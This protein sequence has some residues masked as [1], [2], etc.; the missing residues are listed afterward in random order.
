[1]NEP[2]PPRDPTELP[3][4]GTEELALGYVPPDPDELPPVELWRAVGDVRPW[5]TLLVLFPCAAM[6]LLL[7]A[8]HA[9]G[10]DDALL[11]WGANATRLPPLESAW[12]LIAS[13]FLHAGPGHLF[14]NATTLIIFG[15][16]VERVFTRWG[17]WI[18]Y[19]AGGA[20]A[21]LASLA[22]R[23]AHATGG[24]YS[25]G[26][27]GAIFAL[28]GALIVGAIRLRRRL[29]VGRARSLAAAVL[30]LA[31]TGFAAGFTRNGT[32]NIAH[33]AGLASG[34][35]VA[36]VLGVNPRLGG[37]GAN[38]LTRGLGVLAVLALALSLA[39]GIRSGLASR[40]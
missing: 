11:A 7:A 37:R 12:R 21:S 18:V 9:L 36:V 24:S 8:R 20:L 3:A 28:G 30:Y 26:A 35:L 15:P 27:S 34:A 6:F 5:G 1:M 17:F 2:E 29:A 31:G 22:W 13:T 14:F 16:A 40:G 32:D 23:G 4:N 25:V 19:A 10:E 38:V 33:A 39:W